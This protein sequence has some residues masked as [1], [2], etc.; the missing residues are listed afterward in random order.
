MKYQGYDFFDHARIIGESGFC[1][2]P[3]TTAR[4]ATFSYAKAFDFFPFHASWDAALHRLR[5][6][7][8]WI[9]IGYSLPDADFAFKHLLK[10]TQMA[11]DG[12][13]K[14]IHV[15]AKEK[16]DTIPNRFRQFFGRSIADLPTTVLRNG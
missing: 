3:K 6:A 11:G 5:A 12:A 9:F 15:V 2:N 16:D 1:Q 4:L 13:H 14:E 7:R 10:T 8:R